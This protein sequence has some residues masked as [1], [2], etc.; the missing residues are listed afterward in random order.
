MMK[1]KQCTL[2]HQGLSNGTKSV[3]RGIVVWEINVT[4][5]T[6]YALSFTNTASRYKVGEE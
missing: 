2:I 5:K 4:N 1:P 6:N 3:A